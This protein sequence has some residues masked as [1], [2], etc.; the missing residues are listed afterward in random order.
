MDLSEASLQPPASES[1]ISRPNLSNIHQFCRD[2]EPHEDR[3]DEK[4]RR[5]YYCAHKQCSY[6]VTVTT[7]VR[8]HLKKHQIYIPTLR[9]QSEQTLGG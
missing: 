6:R 8:N 7:N 3:T 5:Y 4:G 9:T 2:P 1:D